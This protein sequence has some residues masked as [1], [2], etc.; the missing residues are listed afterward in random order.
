[1]LRIVLSYTGGGV[2]GGAG[3]GGC[4]MYDTTPPPGIAI[5]FPEG[6]LKVMGLSSSYANLSKLMWTRATK[7]LI[8]AKVEIERICVWKE[9]RCQ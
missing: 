1:M 6:S 8:C 9:H 5:I 4:G 7:S 3:G 2:G